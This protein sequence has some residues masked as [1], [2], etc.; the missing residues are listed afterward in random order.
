M[1]STMNLPSTSRKI[2]QRGM[3][4]WPTLRLLELS[5]L[6]TVYPLY[7]AI[8]SFR[9]SSSLL[10]SVVLVETHCVIDRGWN[11]LGTGVV[12]GGS[13]FDG[14]G[15]DSGGNDS[16]SGSWG[17]ETSG[18]GLVL[19]SC[20]CLVWVLEDTFQGLSFSC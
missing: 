11:I 2:D 1:H 16:G 4:L 17:T 8:L 18:T 6:C 7:T 9:T 3:E 19:F 13:D 14:R 12:G 15:G 10:T 20:S 5:G